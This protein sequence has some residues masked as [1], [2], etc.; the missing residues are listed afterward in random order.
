MIKVYK[1]SITTY[2]CKYINFN[3]IENSEI[4]LMFTSKSTLAKTILF[5]FLSAGLLFNVACQREAGT[6]TQEA[7]SD[8]AD[9]TAETV[10]EGAAT[11]QEGLQDSIDA[12]NEKADELQEDINE[13]TEEAADSAEDEAEEIKEDAQEAQM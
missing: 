11:A 6:E 8:A 7:V 10:K 2:Y 1:D 3:F 13:K 4:I 9:S 5:V 12:A